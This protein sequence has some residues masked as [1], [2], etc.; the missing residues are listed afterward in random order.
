MNP[1]GALGHQLIPSVTFGTGSTFYQVHQNR[2]VGWAEGKETPVLEL[3][4]R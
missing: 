1:A 3:I 4:E 2:L